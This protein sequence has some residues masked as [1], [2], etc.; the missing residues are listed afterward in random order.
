MNSVPICCQTS[1]YP[2]QENIHSLKLEMWG[3]TRH[4]TTTRQPWLN[5]VVTSITSWPMSSTRAANFMSSPTNKF[6]IKHVL[7]SNHHL[8][9]RRIPPHQ[10][11]SIIGVSR[12]TLSDVT[13]ATA[14]AMA[15]AAKFVCA[16]MTQCMMLPVLILLPVDFKLNG[17]FVWNA[18]R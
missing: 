12:Q 18:Q 9:P 16:M 13:T 5:S 15:T 6:N 14:S 8:H 2:F 11:G 4:L 7:I 1:R 3:V 17:E 10:N